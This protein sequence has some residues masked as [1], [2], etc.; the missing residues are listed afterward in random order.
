MAKEYELVIGDKNW[1][2]WSLRP[3]LLMRQAGL[4]FTEI[5]VLLR[6]PETKSSILQHS[7]SGLVPA[8]KW[9]GKVICDSLAICEL[10]ADLY[11]EKKL[12]PRD[13]LTRALARSVACEMHSGFRDLRME[14]PM[15]IVNHYPD[16]PRSDA[17]KSDIRR[18]VSVWREMRLQYGR[19]MSGDQGFLFGHFT[20]ADAM[21]APVVTRFA[22]Y[23]V[24]LVEAGDDGV[25]RAYM[26]CVMTLPAMRDWAAGAQAGLTAR[27]A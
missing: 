24:D 20:V 11:P 2:S 6:S 23:D 3:W 10:I 16:A 13:V 1:S 15:D 22:T 4:D 25:A 17:V 19:Q 27:Q 21:Y 14:L 8:L 5:P 26:N 7:P 12:W 9:R 18:I